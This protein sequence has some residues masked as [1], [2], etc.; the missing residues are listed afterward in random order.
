MRWCLQLVVSRWREA[1]GNTDSHL[2]G[3]YFSLKGGFSL[4]GVWCQQDRYGRLVP[5]WWKSQASGDCTRKEING[6]EE[7]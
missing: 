2:R 3:A 4:P 6:Y 5:G 1:C 7:N